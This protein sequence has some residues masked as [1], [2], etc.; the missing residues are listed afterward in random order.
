LLDDGYA[1]VKSTYDARG[2]ETRESYHGVNG[3]PVVDKH[4][5]HGWA[6]RYDER[7]NEIERI[8]F[9]LDGKP[10]P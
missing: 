6:A 7:G 10:R 8:V 2:K 9:G 3:G 1:T 5:N 4:G